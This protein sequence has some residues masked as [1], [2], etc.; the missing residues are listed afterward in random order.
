M[1]LFVALTLTMQAVMSAITINSEDEQLACDW[2]EP[3]ELRLLNL[4]AL[5]LVALLL[6]LILYLLCYH[7]S[8]IQ[9]G[10][11]TFQ[12]M[13]IKQGRRKSKVIVKVSESSS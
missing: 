9:K 3:W 11:S 13:Q 7:A 4:V 1:L 10:L 8:L 6:L 12:H 5:V 2:V